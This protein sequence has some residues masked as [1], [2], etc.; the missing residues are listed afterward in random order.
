MWFTGPRGLGEKD[1]QFPLYGHYEEEAM[2]KSK[3]KKTDDPFTDKYFE[4]M[5]VAQEMALKAEANA[6]EKNRAMKA[7]LNAELRK[8]KIELQNE[9]NE[10]Y[11]MIERKGLSA[12]S[13][14]ER[15]QQF[16]EAQEAVG[17]IDDGLGSSSIKHPS[18]QGFGSPGSISNGGS[19]RELK[20]SLTYSGAYEHT[21]QTR[22][23][24]RQATVAQERQDAQLENIERGVD[25]LKEIGTAMGEE[26]ERH[27]VVIDEVGDKMEVVTREL[28][29][30][31][32]KLKG[33]LT[34]VRSSRRIFID[35]ILICILLAVGLYIYNMF[36]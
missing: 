13:L 30:N 7:A 22:E 24:V 11:S 34:Q 21:E 2:K 23:F 6:G 14:D 9:V 20:G 33:V 15:R 32:M 27:D 10:L 26:L 18:R 19:A 35:I 3:R 4:I 1:C 8:E 16:E 36:K 31:N 5:D 12:E 28:Q 29:T 17:A 25:T